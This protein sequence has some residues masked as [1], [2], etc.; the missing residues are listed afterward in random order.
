M[1]F[2][3]LQDACSWG[4]STSFFQS[5][6][7]TTRNQKKD[8]SHKSNTNNTNNSKTSSNH[9]IDHSNHHNNNTYNHP[10][11]GFLFFL[12]SCV[13]DLYH[14]GVPNS[15]R[16]ACRCPSYWTGRTTRIAIRIVQKSGSK[17]SIRISC[18]RMTRRNSKF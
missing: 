8:S 1:L 3:F 6:K 13:G 16:L 14:F 2:E 10:G 15:P 4:S 7:D 5:G 17:N 18:S 11:L 12:S 9:D